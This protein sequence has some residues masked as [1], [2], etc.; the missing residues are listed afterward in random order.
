MKIAIT[1]DIHIGVPGKL[2]HNMWGLRRIRQHCIDNDMKYIIVLGD[3]LHDREHIRIEDLNI[4][5]DF[6]IETDEKY[7][8]TVITF[9]GNHD[10]YLKNSWD[11]NS[12]KPL[13]RYTKSYHKV[14]KLKLGGVRFWIVP[15]IYYE[16]EYMK[17]LDKIY[18]QHQ[19]GDVLLTHIGVKSATLNACF[20]LKSWSVVDF[21]ESPFDRV[22]AG[23][24]HIQQQ[25]GHNVWYP[26]SPVPFRFDEG[27]AAHGFFTFDTT[28]RTHEFIDLWEGAGD[29][30]PPQLWTI[31]DSSIKTIETD[32]VKGNII[33]VALSQEYTHNQLSEIRESLSALGAKD[34]RWLNL[35]SKEEKQGIDAAAEIAASASSLFERFVEADKDGTKDLDVNLLLKF[36][37]SI[38]ADG[39]RKYTEQ[40]VEC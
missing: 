26:G 22:Y 10:M 34:V 9:P 17:T 25:V 6:L 30:A 1:A 13:A 8:I 38:V 14:S 32:T 33:R 18:K 28:T 35:A 11:I 23:H 3:L 16:D 12:L 24:F 5:V 36:N 27:D 29:D 37:A 31:D 7:G 21:A 4:L 39:D 2:Q 20:L 15:F 40:A 19:E